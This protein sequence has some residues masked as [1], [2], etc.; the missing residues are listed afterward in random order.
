MPRNKRVVDIWPIS[1]RWDAPRLSRQDPT[2]PEGKMSFWWHR[3]PD[4]EFTRKIA[5]SKGCVARF[6][7]QGV[8]TSYRWVHRLCAAR[9]GYA[10][11][12][13]A[14]T[15]V[16]ILTYPLQSSAQRCVGTIILVEALYRIGF[17]NTWMIPEQNPWS[18]CNNALGALDKSLHILDK[19]HRF[20]FV[21]GAVSMPTIGSIHVEFANILL[22]HGLFLPLR[23][24]D[25]VVAAKSALEYIL[26]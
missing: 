12:P 16:E 2:N 26:G 21:H 11:F 6:H 20:V 14:D 7:D 23:H 22:E 9:Y 8:T 1:C 18:R 10:Q 13:P 15:L 24:L 4:P 5:E 3:Y 17:P 19:K 25:P